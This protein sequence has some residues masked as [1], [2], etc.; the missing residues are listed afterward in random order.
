NALQDWA[1]KLTCL[2]WV[3]AAAFLISALLAGLLEIEWIGTPFYAAS[4]AVFLFGVLPFFLSDAW[5]H[6][7]AATAFALT[8]LTL[9]AWWAWVSR[10]GRVVLAAGVI[11]ASFASLPHGGLQYTDYVSL[12]ILGRVWAAFFSTATILAVYAMVLRFYGKPG[13]ALLA[14]AF[15]AFS[16]SSIQVAHYCITESFITLML[17]VVALLSRRIFEKGDWASY[18]TAGAAFGISMAA[19]TSSLYYVLILVMAHL[20][21]LSRK[22]AAEWVRED[23]KHADNRDVFTLLA[24]G[25]LVVVAVVFAGV[26]YKLKGVLQDLFYNGNQQVLPPAWILMMLLAVGAGLVLALW[27]LKEFKAV[28]GQIPYWL[29]LTA[30]GALSFL[31]FCLFS[32]WSLLD[33]T[34]FQ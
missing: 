27:G 24:G 13:L 32:P 31:M 20:L 19:K 17:V 29:R 33:F 21:F 34:G 5:S 22:K 25:L 9:G 3:A 30:A 18:L 16:V 8:V 11:W 2:G 12:M 10:W 1:S 6:T 28:R 15:F 4:G 23:R 7:F 14:S 26:V